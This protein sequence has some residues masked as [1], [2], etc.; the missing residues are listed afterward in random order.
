MKGTDLGGKVGDLQRG[1][2]PFQIGVGGEQSV[3]LVY[4]LIVGF[5]IWLD[6]KLRHGDRGSYST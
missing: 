5:A 4:A 1:S 3:E 6:E 2:D